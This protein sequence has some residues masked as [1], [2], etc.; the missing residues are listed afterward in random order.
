[1]LPVL[2]RNFKTSCLQT[3]RGWFSSCLKIRRSALDAHTVLLCA[4]REPTKLRLTKVPSLPQPGFWSEREDLGCNSQG[5]DFTLL[6][7]KSNTNP[8]NKVGGQLTWSILPELNLEWAVHA[9]ST[10]RLTHF[11]WNCKLNTKR[12]F[13]QITFFPEKAEDCLFIF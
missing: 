8:K 13:Y 10:P 12:T 11:G 5:P 9:T 6:P 1:M 3:F 2:N 4:F 7:S